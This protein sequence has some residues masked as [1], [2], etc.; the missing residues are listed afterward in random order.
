MVLLFRSSLQVVSIRRTKRIAKAMMES[1][2]T[3]R[4]L[5]LLVEAAAVEVVIAKLAY[6]KELARTLR[7]KTKMLVKSTVMNVL[8]TIVTG[9]NAPIQASL[10]T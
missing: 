10:L 9:L 2:R 6:P 3:L 8:F 7:G 4:A 1:P 5:R